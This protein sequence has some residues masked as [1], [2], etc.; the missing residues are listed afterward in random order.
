MAAPDMSTQTRKEKRPVELHDI[1]GLV[2]FGHGQLTESR[3]LL[4][5]ITDEV[6]ARSWLLQ[7]PV[8]TAQEQNPKPETALQVAFSVDGLRALGLQQ[9]IIEGFSDE[10]IGGLC[11]DENRSRRL[12]DTENNAPQQWQWGGALNKPHLICYYCYT[13]REAK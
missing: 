8:T 6:I 11:G 1:Q 12:G 10:F 3:F 2:R 13:V 5:Q 4:L 9:N 7:A